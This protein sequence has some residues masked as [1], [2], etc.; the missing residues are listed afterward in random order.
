M[1]RYNPRK[2]PDSEMWLSIDEQERIYLVESFHRS[3][4]IR[5]PNI[6]LHAAM[7]AIVENQIAEQ[8]DPVVRA[9]DRL[10]AEG[11]SRHECIH[12]IAWVLAQELFGAMQSTSEISKVNAQ[13]RYDSAIERFSA[14]SWRAQADND[15]E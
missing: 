12:A 5:L 10:A 3:E 9:M 4:R 15:A 14:V 2:P 1:Y 6:K 8:H 7:H 13:A 11:L